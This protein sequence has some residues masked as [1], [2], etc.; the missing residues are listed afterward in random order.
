[1]LNNLE[2]LPLFSNAYWGIFII[3]NKKNYFFFRASLNDE[4]II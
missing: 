1:M 3:T 2:S 4:E